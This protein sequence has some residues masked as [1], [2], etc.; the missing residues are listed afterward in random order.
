[1]VDI[2]ITV[3]TM[4]EVNWPIWRRI[5]AAIE[6][7]GFA[8]AYRSD[9]LANPEPPDARSLDMVVSLA[10][11]ADHTKRVRFGPL[12]A[13]LSFR[14]PVI[15][16]HQA[17]ALDSL[18]DGRMVL[19]LGAGWAGREHTMFGF[20]LGD[21]AA[22][23]D[24]L[25][26]GVA[27]IAHLLRSDEPLTHAGRFYSLSEARLLAPKA[28]PQGPPIMIGGNGPRRTL[29]LVARHADIW[30]A[31]YMAPAEFAERSA[32]LDALLAAAGRP[33]EA[34]RR[35][36]LLFPILGHDGAGLERRTQVWRS[37][38]AFA[39]LA[40]DDLLAQMRGF[41]AFVGT[42]AELVALLHS[43]A[44]A[45]VQEA[46]IQWFDPEDIEGLQQIADEVLPRL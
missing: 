4:S 6:N 39:S 3:E 23:A 22:R 30:N 16:A 34:V 18:S 38:P 19:G 20:S 41:G 21:V 15:L 33:P 29:P 27:I 1:M 37:D 42:P 44:E 2:S 12:V 40:L 25:D 24:R 28:R 32:Q 13:P 36:I 31:L 5:V 14:D 9:H 7:L 17:A 8:G 10:Y 43:Y 26:E 46:M 11:L 35:T 45:G